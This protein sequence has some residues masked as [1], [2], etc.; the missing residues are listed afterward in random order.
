MASGLKPTILIIGTDITLIYLFSRFAEQNG[1]QLTSAKDEISLVDIEAAQP[2]AILFLSTD[3]LA[4]HEALLAELVNRDT[5]ILVCASAAE[6]AHARELGADYCL[7]HPLTY[8]DF[9]TALGT[10]TS[11]KRS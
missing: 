11:S 7:L 4:K 5:P 2:A 8:T 3:I 6:E 1:Y 9:Q 10:V